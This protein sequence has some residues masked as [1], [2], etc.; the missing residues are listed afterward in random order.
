MS[1]VSTDIGPHG[2]IRGPELNVPYYNYLQ[3]NRNQASNN[4]NNNNNNGGHHRLNVN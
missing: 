1:T 3:N 2:M 4:D